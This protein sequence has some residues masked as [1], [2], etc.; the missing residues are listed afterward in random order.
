MTTLT[1]VFFNNQSPVNQLES[2]LP[3]SYTMTT[4]EQDIK[5]LESQGFNYVEED[6]LGGYWFESDDYTYYVD[7]VGDTASETLSMATLYSPCC[8]EAV[9]ED[10]MICPNCYEHV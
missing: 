7:S 8:S 10:Y 9:D 3:K 4:Q 6:V 5:K 1:N 2:I